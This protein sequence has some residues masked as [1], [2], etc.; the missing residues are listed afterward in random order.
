MPAFNEGESIGSV[1]SGIQ[2]RLPEVEIIV[3]DDGSA[4]HTSEIAQ[5]AGVRVIRHDRNQGY[6]CSL[7][8]GILAS[9]RR[10]VFFCDADGQHSA[11]DVAT[12]IEA[13]DTYDMVIGV[14][15][16][17]YYSS[18][19]RAP[20]KFIMR[21]FTNYLAGQKIPDL[22]SGLRM[23]KKEVIVKY[24]HLMPDGFSFS[25]T[26]TFALLKG[27]YRIKWVPITVEKSK[28]K[29]MVRQLKH[30]PQTLMLI[31]RLA[32]LFE[33]LKV[34]LH[35]SAVLLFFSVASFT[36]DMYYSRFQK[37]STTTTLFAV[38]T[39]L[40]FMVGLICDQVSAIRRELH[41]R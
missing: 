35:T 16:K 41:D 33:P 10:Y 3:V 11:E 32:V 24:L 40:V 6:G 8:T 20:G 14:R 12:I 18:M 5:E 37:I 34:F 9:E 25:S 4:D 39:M 36:F 15:G 2:A 23:I 21:T 17:G 30:G 28:G 22:N 1:L 7:R 29:S 31:L 26:S 38:A 19:K 13:C 27:K